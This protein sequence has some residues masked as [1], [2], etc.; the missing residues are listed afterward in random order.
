MALADLLRSL[1]DDAA[2]Q[3]AGVLAAARADADALE[4]EASRSRDERR[5]EASEQHA[6]ACQGTAD[7]RVATAQREARNQVLVA[8]AAML[9]R[10][11]AALRT[12]LRVLGQ[13]CELIDALARAVIANAG[14][15]PGVLY[16]PPSL[17][18]H[19]RTLA[20]PTLR[21]EANE[22]MTT[23]VSIVLATGTEI[24]AT[25]D[26]LAD[27]EWPALA[28]TALRLAKERE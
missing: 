26:S 24:V 18:V 16:G 6:R 20:P 4:A 13:S 2:S 28:A 10:I 25:L 23:G 8:R 12:R 9:D 14:D 11:R 3:I 27:R 17:L 19:L 7:A 22:D 1:E 21:V 5:R 15:R